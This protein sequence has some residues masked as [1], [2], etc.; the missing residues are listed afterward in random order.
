M[1]CEALT[2]TNEVFF[3]R[4]VFVDVVESDDFF[5]LNPVETEVTV[6]GLNMV[7]TDPAMLILNRVKN[8]QNSAS[9]SLVAG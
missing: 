4:F 6:K 5:D 7:F 2:K 3:H 1:A 9:T 8:W